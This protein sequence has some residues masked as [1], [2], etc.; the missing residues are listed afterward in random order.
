MITCHPIPDV[1]PGPAR[2]RFC[3]SSEEP[4]PLAIVI[5]QP[6]FGRLTLRRF[7]RHGPDDW[8]VST[9]RHFLGWG[10]E[11]PIRRNDVQIARE[12]TD[13]SRDCVWVDAPADADEILRRIFA[14]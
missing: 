10:P 3:A 12:V 14:P 9:L 7:Y 13:A 2:P 6:E 5:A 4:Q 11:E 1:E 8:S